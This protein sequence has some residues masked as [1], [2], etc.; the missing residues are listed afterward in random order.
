MP[1][2]KG[3]NA[4]PN[5][6]PKKRPMM[7]PA[8]RAILG[9]RAPEEFGNVTNRVAIAQKLVEIALGG[10][11]QAIKLIYERVDGKVPDPVELSGPDGGALAFDDV[12][13]SD[14]ERAKR[15]SAILAAALREGDPGSADEP[16][17][18][19]PPAGAA[20]DGLLQ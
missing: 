14:A 6:R 9:K 2:Q 15:I 8:L 5:G 3:N 1:F 12:G 7:T 19:V 10:D 16:P 13:L 18:V 11:T 20:D 4:N 17:A